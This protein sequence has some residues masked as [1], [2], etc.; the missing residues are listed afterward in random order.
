[1]LLFRPAPPPANTGQCVA[2][3]ARLLEAAGSVPSSLP[4]AATAYFDLAELLLL[5]AASPVRASGS[6]VLGCSQ[7]NVLLLLGIGRPALSTALLGGKTAP[8]LVRLLQW[9]WPGDV[10]RTEPRRLGH[11]WPP[12]RLP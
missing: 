7:S 11:L 9:P 8:P 2:H 1:M 10:L 4:V 6:P 12:V 5:I 3:G